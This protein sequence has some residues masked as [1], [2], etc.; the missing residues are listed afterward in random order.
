MCLYIGM[1]SGTYNHS[2]G[3]IRKGPG[4]GSFVGNNK[5][6]FAQ[7]LNLQLF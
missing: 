1:E 3:C 4:V 2:N 5:F 7:N 6:F